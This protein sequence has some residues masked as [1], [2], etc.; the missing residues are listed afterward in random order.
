MRRLQEDE[1]LQRVI[2][3]AKLSIPN[4]T[5]PATSIF[6][7]PPRNNPTYFVDATLISILHIVKPACAGSSGKQ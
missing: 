4:T 5:L 6:S 7:F 2:H 3:A 1:R